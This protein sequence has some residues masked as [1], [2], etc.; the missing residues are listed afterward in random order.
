MK[1]NKAIKTIPVSTRLTENEIIELHELMKALECENQ[2]QTLRYSI[3]KTI[4]GVLNN[5]C[6]IEK[7]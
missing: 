7:S 1:N 3:K 4:K 5:A 6:Q 2:S